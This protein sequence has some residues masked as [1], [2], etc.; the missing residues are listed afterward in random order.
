M[1]HVGY[2]LRRG[3]FSIMNTTHGQNSQTKTETVRAIAGKE[4]DTPLKDSG[5]TS[6]T[7]GGKDSGPRPPP[8]VADQSATEGL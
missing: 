5:S 2:P 6:I 7:K 4:T 3:Y 1:L 8:A